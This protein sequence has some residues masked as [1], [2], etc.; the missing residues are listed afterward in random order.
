MNPLR[1]LVV[2][3]DPAISS[4]MVSILQMLGCRVEQAEN[5]RE[6]ARMLERSHYNGVIYITDPDDTDYIELLHFIQRKFPGIDLIIQLQTAST[7]FESDALRE[8]VTAVVQP[9]M[10]TASLKPVLCQIKE[11]QKR[12]QKD[13]T[14]IS[15]LDQNQSRHSHSKVIPGETNCLVGH[16]A[17][18]K[19][20][21]NLA[22]N[23]VDIDTPVLILGDRGTGKTTLARWIHSHGNRANGQIV[24]VNCQNS[25]ETALESEI[26]GVQTIGPDGSPLQKE[27]KLEEAQNGTIVFDEPQFLSPALQLKILRFLQTGEYLPIGSSTYRQSNARPIFT[28]R[29]AISSLVQ[30]DRFRQDLYYRISVI[31]LKLPPL[32]LRGNDIE[33]LSLHFLSIY[34]RRLSKPIRE[35]SPEAMHVLCD[36]G[37]PGNVYELESVIHRGVILAQNG[38]IQPNHLVMMPSASQPQPRSLTT[39]SKLTGPMIRPLKE[40]LAEPEKQLI[41]QALEALNWNRQETA[42][43]LDINRT[44]LYKKMKKYHLLTEEDHAEGL[45]DIA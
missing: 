32:C 39:P 5:D 12:G 11:S 41:L 18:L 16:D 22:S 31:A 14:T 38:I 21:L 25:S 19:K 1:M 17:S 35:I 45:I 37:W 13:A 44:T 34:G 36:H 15:N 27:G 10:S 28:T 7:G 20:T 23:V 2:Q 3:P 43:V 33:L 24:E 42:R 4:S 26:F 6:A 29:E 8:G 40:S 30:R 9:P